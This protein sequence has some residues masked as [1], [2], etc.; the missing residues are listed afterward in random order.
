MK[1]RKGISGSTLKIIAIITMLIDHIGAG[2]LGRLLVVRGMNEAADLNAWIDANST[3][4]ITYQMMRFVG[5]LAFPIFCF[6]LIEGFEHTHDVKKYAL[7]L[8]SFC[9]V[10][11]IPFDLLF[12]GKILES[13]YQ[14]VFFTLFLGLVCLTGL[15][16]VSQ[17]NRNLD[18]K[19]KAKG[20]L[21]QI[22]II[23]I[24]SC[25]AE[26]LKCDYGAQGIIFIAGF[27]IFRKSHVLQVVMFLVLYMATTG[28][29]PPT[30]TMIAAFL[31]LLYNGKRGKWKAKYLF[32]WFYPIHIFV[33]Y[34]IAQLFL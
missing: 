18:R 24:V 3:L 30:Y 5:R 31:L 22:G 16:A 11:E 32:Y 17:R 6:L 23:A 2:V 7:R 33:L 10:S 25:A 27:Y 12:N 20:L 14:N 4:V 28:N 13:G 15:E 26:L 21:L 29:Q 8:L 19:E 9:L 34:V 1:E